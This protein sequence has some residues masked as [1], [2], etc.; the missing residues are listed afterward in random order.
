MGEMAEAPQALDAGARQPRL[1]LARGFRRHGPVLRGGDQ[2][3][4]RFQL[5]EIALERDKIPVRQHGEHPLHMGLVAKQAHILVDPRRLDHRAHAAQQPAHG[6]LVGGPG[7]EARRDGIEEQ[8]SRHRRKQMPRKPLEGQEG[9]VEAH[10]HFGRDQ[11]VKAHAGEDRRACGMAH[12]DLG[13][14]IERAQQLM[15]RLAHGGQRGD[16]GS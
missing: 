13:L 1:D 14:E 11:P 5:R 9:A 7:E 2:G 8:Q 16:A 10:Q 4:R 12:H 15:Q 3:Q 6:G